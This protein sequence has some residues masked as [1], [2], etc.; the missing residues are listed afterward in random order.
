MDCVVLAGGIPGPADPLFIHTQGKPKALI[1]LGQSTMLEH[2]IEALVEAKSVQ[3]IAV[4]GLESIDT[5]TMSY[6]I[7]FITNKGTMVANAIAGAEWLMQSN[8]DASHALFCTSDIP[9][10]TGPI[11]D[12]FIA[13]CL[14]LSYAAY[15]SMVTRE[16]MEERFPESGRTYVNLGSIHLAG[17]DLVVGRPD[18]VKTNREIFQLIAGGR[19]Q[20]WKLARIVGPSTLLRF[21]LHRLTISDIEKRAQSILH[22]PVKVIVSADPELAMDVDKPDQL[23]LIRQYLGDSA[24]I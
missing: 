10:V 17:G 22:Q 4:V 20:A 18:L 3:N 11:I 1:H 9:L 15:Y 14:P 8:Q 23:A 16:V 21:L 7:T 2:V 12:Q 19:K 24:T 5:L 6:P 13:R